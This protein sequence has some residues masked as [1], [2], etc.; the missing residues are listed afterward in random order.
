MNLEKAKKIIRAPYKVILFEL[1]R[2]KIYNAYIHKALFHLRSATLNITDNC[3]SRCIMCSAWRQKSTNELTT[4]EVTDIL[5]QLRKLGISNLGFAGGEPLLRKDLPKLVQKSK[6]LGFK[7]ISIITNGLLLNE[8]RAKL[9]LKSG[10]TAMGISIDG[11]GETHDMI[12]GIKGA[13]E[14]SSSALKTLVELRDD[15]YPYLDIWVSTILIRPN[16]NQ[17]EEIIKMC[18]QLNVRI[19]LNLPDTSPYFFSGVDTSDLMIK[20]QKELDAFIDRLHAIKKKYPSVLSQFHVSLEYARKH[21][22]DPKRKDIPCY[23]GYQNIYIGA[24]GEVYSGCWVLKPLGNLRERKLEEV[25]SSEE[26]KKRLYN[27]FMKKCPGC[28][29]GYSGNLLYH[30]PSICNEIIWKLKGNKKI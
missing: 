24:H 15:K 19:A 10:L 27:M 3:N 28:S 22:S 14:R 4:D 20:D 8:R 12:R 29:C 1:M 5:S 13:Y 26:Y 11:I 9:L 18:K 30:L 7:H 17:I 2:Y 6:E 21:F 16:M 23:M 25:M